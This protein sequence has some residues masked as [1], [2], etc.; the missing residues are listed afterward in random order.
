MTKYEDDLQPFLDFG[1]RCLSGSFELI[2]IVIRTT[3]TIA[4]QIQQVYSH[5]K[6]LF[7]IISYS[8]PW[9]LYSGL[10][11]VLKESAGV[12][13]NLETGVMAVESAA[14]THT[15]SQVI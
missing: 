7:L 15:I 2:F 3:F 11:L 8:L 14:V 1:I 4:L 9:K 12:T 13:M 10:S 5:N 6:I